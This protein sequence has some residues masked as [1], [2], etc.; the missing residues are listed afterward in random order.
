MASRVQKL[1]DSCWTVWDEGLG[2]VGAE[3]YLLGGWRQHSWPMKHVLKF[4]QG[5]RTDSMACNEAHCP[6][7]HQA[8][9][10]P[11]APCLTFVDIFFLKMGKQNKINILFLHML[12]TK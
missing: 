6:L 5:T 3:V 4:P 2:H 8:F 7:W 1:N 12:T 11:W 10:A 9:S